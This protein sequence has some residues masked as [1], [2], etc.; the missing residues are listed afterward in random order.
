MQKRLSIKAIA[1]DLSISPTTV[2]FVLNN[3][4]LDKRISPG[5]IEKVKDYI[6]KIGYQPNQMAQCL[7]TGKSGIVVFMVE[8][9]SNPFFACVAKIIEKRLFQE[10]YTTIYCSTD[11]DVG[12]TRRLIRQF[13]DLRVDA[14]IISPP[15]GFSPCELEPLNAPGKSV[16]LFEGQPAD[17]GQIVNM[18]YQCGKTAA[19]V[20]LSN[21]IYPQ[22]E[23]ATEFVR[24]T[25]E[26]LTNGNKSNVQQRN[27]ASDSYK[28]TTNSVI[29]QS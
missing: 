25:L 20:A 7:R 27:I 1:K 22:E 17:G 2:S 19:N 16:V 8:D 11:G 6:E 5:V 24:V 13:H 23:L 9:I 15:A 28:A 26:L 29:G 21:S 3:K 14:Y 18:A 4:A 10:G 12:K